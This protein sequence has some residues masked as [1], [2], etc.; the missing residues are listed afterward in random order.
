MSE[1]KVCLESIS[2]QSIETAY[3][4]LHQ[5]ERVYRYSTMDWQRDDIEYA[6]A[7]FV[8]NSMPPALYQWLA[9]GRFDYL[10]DHV[11]FFDDINDALS[12]LEDLL[13]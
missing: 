10:L 13:S 1:N 11:R 6:I 3:C 7:Q 8:D 2:R 12:R 9:Q 4:L 5:K